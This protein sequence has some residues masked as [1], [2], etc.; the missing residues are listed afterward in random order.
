[1]ITIAEIY[2]GAEN[3]INQLIR[4]ESHAQGHYLSGAM[5]E[6]LSAEVLKKG[7]ADVMEGF[8]VDYTKFVNEGV[9]AASASMRQFPFVYKYFLARGLADK[10]AK[11]AAA[12]TIKKWMKEGMST[13]ASKRFSQTGA[14]QHMIESAFIGGKTQI[15]EYMTNLFDY[16]ME[17]QFQQTKSETV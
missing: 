9:P 6:S 13:Q 16:S 15:D 7:K 11:G 4:K 2:R 14:R 5:E 12:A 3:L 8:A 1:M 10:E 17:E